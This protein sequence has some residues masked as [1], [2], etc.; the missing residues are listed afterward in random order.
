MGLLLGKAKKKRVIFYYHVYLPKFVESIPLFGKTKLLK[1]FFK[2]VTRKFSNMCDLVVVPS[3]AVC[4]EMEEW[5]VVKSKIRVVPTG[6]D[7]FFVDP[8]SKEVIAKMIG[9]YSHPLILYVG[10]LSQEK[11]IELLILIFL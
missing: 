6:L 7:P 5:G 9:C 4:N 2:F 10:R 11:N 3:N 8:P 1:G